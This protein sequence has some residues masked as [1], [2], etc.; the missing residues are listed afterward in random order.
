VPDHYWW[1]V[2]VPET[3]AI[4]KLLEAL[5]STDDRVDAC[6]QVTSR[7]MSVQDEA[8]KTL[9]AL[10]SELRRVLDSPPPEET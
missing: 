6:R 9:H 5:R 7:A 3:E 4:I 1:L 2:D 8:E 10:L